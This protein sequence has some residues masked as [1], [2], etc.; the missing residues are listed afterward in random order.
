MDAFDADVLIYAVTP[1]HLL[2]PRVRR[3][4]AE[5]PGRHV[6]IG[7]VVLLPEVLA[8]PLRNV[9][10]REIAELTRLLSRLDLRS[11]DPVIAEA[12]T[13][14]QPRIASTQPTHS[15]SRPPS[16]PAPT[17]SSRT[18]AATSGRPSPRSRWCTRTRWASRDAEPSI[19]VTSGPADGGTDGRRAGSGGRSQSDCVRNA[20]TSVARLEAESFWRMRATCCSTVFGEM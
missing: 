15:T 17:A 11:A 20:A 3:L 7:S 13:S 10:T 2:G 8:K 9:S 14:R 5:A 6:G 12:A 18:T 4:F 19:D 16:S 1:D